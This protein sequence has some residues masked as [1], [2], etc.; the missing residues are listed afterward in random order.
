MPTSARLHTGGGSA[1]GSPTLLQLVILGDIREDP[2]S[3]EATCRGAGGLG[4]GIFLVNMSFEEL[5]FNPSQAF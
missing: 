5:Q 1:T 4:Y 2:V 3:Y